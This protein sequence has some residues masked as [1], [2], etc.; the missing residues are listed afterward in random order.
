MESP[1]FAPEENLVIDQ[2][3]GQGYY[4]FPIEDLNLLQALKKR[5]YE[6]GSSLLP[7]AEKPS[8]KDFFDNIHNYV[9]VKDLNEFRMKIIT[10]LAQD[11]ELRP[12]VYALAKK[13]LHL[14]VGNELVMQRNCNLSIQLPGDDSSLLPLHSDVWSGNSP[15][16]V[17]FWLPLV[18]SYQTK[19]MFILPPQ[20]SEEVYK[21]FKDFAKLTTEEFFQKIKPNLVWFEVPY[22]H[23]VIFWHSLPHGNRVNEEKDTRWTINTRFK[24]LLSPYCIKEL[25]ET[26]LPITI[27]PATR[28]GYS[29]RKPEVE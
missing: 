4:V 25:G 16:E 22:G 19:S 17:V 28:L 5:I 27:R 8:Q 15:Y 13:H 1:F 2:F 26:F 18:D 23:G 14:I 21:N 12:Q 24:A 3:L 20:Y 29:Y 6:F 9:S 7:T 11:K 10:H